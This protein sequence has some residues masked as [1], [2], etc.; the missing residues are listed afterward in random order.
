MGPL[1]LQGPSL[2][3]KRFE[4]V[5]LLFLFVRHSLFEEGF[6]QAFARLCVPRW[7]CWMSNRCKLGTF[8]E[9]WLAEKMGNGDGRDSYVPL[10]LDMMN[11]L[12][13]AFLGPHD[14]KPFLECDTKG[15][16]VTLLAA[17]GFQ[18]MD[19]KLWAPPSE[20][21]WWQELLFDGEHFEGVLQWLCNVGEE[22]ALQVDY[23]W[24]SVVPVV[25]QLQFQ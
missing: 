3:N 14:H 9:A 11:D 16:L 8:V 6:C 17:E 25:P 2:K 1:A 4:V 23:C 10:F 5:N 12:W 7:E 22:T 24:R 21:G 15:Q 19:G 18:Y 20:D 13:L